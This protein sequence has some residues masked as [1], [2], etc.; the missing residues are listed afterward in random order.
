MLILTL[1]ISLTFVIIGKYE[2]PILKLNTDSRKQIFTIGKLGL[3]VALGV[4]LYNHSADLLRG[5]HEG[6]YGK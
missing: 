5:F 6:F 3:G 4:L 1:L 2:F